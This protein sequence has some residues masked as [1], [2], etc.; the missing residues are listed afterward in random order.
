MVYAA[1]CYWPGVTAGDLKLAADSAAREA[2]E[3]SRA[4]HG[5]AY[6]GSLLFPDDELVLCLFEATSRAAVKAANERAGIPCERLMQSIWLAR[7][8]GEGDETC[9]GFGAPR[10]HGPIDPR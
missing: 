8:D 5:V 2:E 4:G 10:R 3:L 9:P 6:L 1:K 7:R